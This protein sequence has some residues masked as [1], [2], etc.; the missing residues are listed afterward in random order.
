MIFLKRKM[1]LPNDRNSE[2][3]ISRHVCTLVYCL[4]I[5]YHRDSNKSIQDACGWSKIISSYYI[6]LGHNLINYMGTRLWSTPKRRPELFR[7]I[8]RRDSA[9]LVVVNMISTLVG[10]YV[11]CNTEEFSIE[12][13]LC[14]YLYTLPKFYLFLY[15][16][17]QSYL[18]DT[19]TF[20]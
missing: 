15:R 12:F 19:G 18:A 6:M 5:Y 16:I 14:F 17:I 10:V 2:I 9:F 13:C 3:V 11:W 4:T 20:L 1:I 8:F 7:S